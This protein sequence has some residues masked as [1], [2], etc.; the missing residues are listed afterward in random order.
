MATQPQTPKGCSKSW[1]FQ[2]DK[3]AISWNG[4]RNLK[5]LSSSPLYTAISCVPSISHSCEGLKPQGD[6]EA[7][8]AARSRPW[9]ITWQQPDGLP[10]IA[11]PVKNGD[12]FTVTVPAVWNGLGGSIP[13]RIFKASCA[14][15]PKP[16]RCSSNAGNTT[17]AHKWS[18]LLCSPWPKEDCQNKRNLDHS[19]VQI[20]VLNPELSVFHLQ[21][22]WSHNNSFSQSFSCESSRLKCS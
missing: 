15:E 21:S 18:S 14:I 5:I 22:P 7:A 19:C 1:Y 11:A 13:G 4:L 16:W 20:C 12:F 9:V 8:T 10:V 3:T 17:L 6:H 2:Q